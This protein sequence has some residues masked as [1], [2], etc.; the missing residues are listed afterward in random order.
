MSTTSLREIGSY[1]GPAPMVHPENRPFWSGLDKRRLVVQQCGGCGA[2]RFPVAPM[3]FSCGETSHGW[4]DL[5][6]A[7]RIAVAVTVHR[8]TGDR[9]WTS[10]VPFVVALVDLDGGIRITGRLWCSC[11]RGS[12]PGAATTAVVSQGP[13][14]SVLAFA[15]ACGE[16]TG[17]STYD[18]N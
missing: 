2:R 15:H 4:V 7:G 9:S 18:G 5:P 16:L 14:F 12:R 17:G 8:A 13:G 10:E 3:C 1:H 6:P 11:G